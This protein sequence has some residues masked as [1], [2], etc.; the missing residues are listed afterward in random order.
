MS[1]T[2]SPP[3]RV[4]DRDIPHVGSRTLQEIEKDWE[5]E[6]KRADLFGFRFEWP[7]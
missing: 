7:H 6:E 4:E 3:L 1:V 5:G 2:N